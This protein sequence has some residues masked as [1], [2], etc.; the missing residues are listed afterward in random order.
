MATEAP[1]WSVV[2]LPGVKTK[3][4]SGFDVQ[5]CV[6]QKQRPPAAVMRGTCLLPAVSGH[7][8][9]LGGGGL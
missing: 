2:P 9:Q 8:G 4:N 1:Q 6:L 7:L 3:V 5:V